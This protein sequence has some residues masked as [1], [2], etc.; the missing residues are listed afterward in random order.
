MFNIEW[1]GTD[2]NNF[3][4]GRDDQGVYGI[5][6]HIM[7]GTMEST[8]GWFKNVKSEVSAHF[9]VAKD[10]RIWNWVKAINT[11]W[12][13]GDMQAGLDL[14]IYWLAECWAD[15]VKSK[16][17]NPNRRTISIE[18]EGN[19]GD[20]MPEKQYQA[21]LWLHQQ[22]LEQFAMKADRQHIIQ[23]RQISPKSKPNCPGAGFPMDRLLADLAG[24]MFPPG[25]E[26]DLNGFHVPEPFATYWKKNGGLPVF[27]LPVGNYTI[28]RNAHPPATDYQYFERAR[29]EVQ[30]DGTISRGL[31]GAELLRATGR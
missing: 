17:I 14:G 20:V 23:H 21:T 18:H 7:Q 31:V 5:V 25:N 29:L 8:D 28:D 16:Q 30:P 26:F 3:W 2:G 11:A 4:E 22:L 6:D 19:S 12:A 1:K 9:G 15:G 24:Q 10:G 27:G 13:N